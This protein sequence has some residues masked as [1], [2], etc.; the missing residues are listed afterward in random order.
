MKTIHCGFYVAF[1]GLDGVGKTTTMNAVAAAMEKRLEADGLPRTIVRTSHPG[2]TP[3]GKHI[4][5]LVKHPTTIDPSITIDDLSRQMLYLVDMMS[6]TKTILEPALNFNQIVFGDRHSGI[7]S[8][9]YAQAD[10]IDL[11]DIE[12]LQSIV[13]QPKAD[14]LY[15]LTCPWDVCKKRI[16]AERAISADHYDSK[17]SAFHQRL[18]QLYNELVVG[19]PEFVA[20][21]SRHCRINDV[22]YFDSTIPPDKLVEAITDDAMRAFNERC[23][24]VANE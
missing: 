5:Q 18:S 17:S 1:E 16:S 12:R 24:L 7:S 2:S 4:R 13:H 10:G 11:K 23:V 8:L 9:V 20:A 14:R 22:I 21:V 3:L 19:S 15:V 6:F